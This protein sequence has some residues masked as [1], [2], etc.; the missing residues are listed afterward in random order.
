MTGKD[1]YIYIM[2]LLL[3]SLFITNKMTLKFR[4]EIIIKREIITDFKYCDD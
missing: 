1:V 2:F 4:S 3:L